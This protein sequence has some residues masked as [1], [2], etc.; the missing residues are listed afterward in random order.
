MYGE[1]SQSSSE[2]TR[3]AADTSG[4]SSSV[5]S[6]IC[7]ICLVTFATQEIATTDICDHLFCI[8]CLEE[9]AANVHTCPLDRQEF[10]AILV[11][12]Y[13]DGEIIRRIPLQSREQQKKCDDFIP[14]DE[15]FC[16]FCGYS[17]REESLI[18]C[19]SC[20]FLYHLECASALLLNLSSAELFCPICVAIR[21][22]LAWPSRN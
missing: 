20:A 12:H 11:R 19:Y 2:A 3:P 15:I 7:P 22:Q 8:C 13:P 9:W 18:Y 21:H 6:E 16:A 1:A 14:E 17:L 10:N 4:T 5:D